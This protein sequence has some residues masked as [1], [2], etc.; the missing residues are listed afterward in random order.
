MI[1]KQDLVSLTLPQV[2]T[3]VLNVQNSFE[4][5]EN[6]DKSR[7]IQYIHDNTIKIKI[8]KKIGFDIIKSS[9]FVIEYVYNE[10]ISRH[11][12][13]E[14][15]EFNDFESFFEYVE[16]KIYDFSC[17]Y[18]YIFSEEEISKYDIDISKINFDS[19][20][21][22]DITKKTFESVVSDSKLQNQ[23]AIEN[24]IKI[25]KWIS[26]INNI[27]SYDSFIKKYRYFETKFT[28]Y[29]ATKI[30]FSLLIQKFG[31]LI[32]DYIVEFRRHN[33]AYKGLDI[34]DILFYYGLESAEQVLVGFDDGCAKSTI[35]RHK[36]IIKDK[37]A[38]FQNDDLIIQKKG[39][40][41]EV[42]QLYEVNYSYFSNKEKIPF[43]IVEKYLLTF[44]DFLK[45]LDFDLSGVNL[46][47]APISSNDVLKYKTDET[48]KLPRPDNYALYRVEKFYEDHQF[49]VVQYW[50]DKNEN[51]IISNQ[52][53]FQFFC[54]FAHYLNNDL[55]NA[56]LIMCDG[57]EKISS[58]KKI[59]FLGVKVRSE[60]AK[61]FNIKLDTLPKDKYELNEFE[62]TKKNELVTIN[63]LE[64][65]RATDEDYSCRV[66]Y[67]T[68]IH[69]IHRFAAWKCETFSDLEY[70]IKV[71]T[72]TI[73]RDLS[74]IKLIGGDIASDFKLYKTFIT[75]L[76]NQNENG[77]IFITL[78]NH[79]LWPF[80]DCFLDFIVNQYKEVINENKM[81]LVHNNLFYFD[82]E[83][84][85]ISTQ[86]LAEVSVEELRK[87]MRDA[88]LIIFGGI[89][90]AGKNEEFNANF[91]IYR[92]TISRK[93]EVEQSNLF[94][95]LYSK[96]VDALYDKNVIIFTHMPINDWTTNKYNK[97][98]VYVSGHNH[99]NY[100]HD[101]GVERVYS[102]NQIGYKQKNLY[103]KNFSINIG[104]D[105]FS[106]YKDGI[107]EISKE[108][109]ILFYKGIGERLSFN[110]QYYKLYMLKREETYMFLMR[111]LSGS[112]LILNGGAIKNG[113]NHSIEYFYDNL[114]T[115]SK[116]IKM[117]LSSFD[118]FQK[119]VSKEIKSI[120]GDGRIHGSIVDI[121]F[122]NHLYLNPLD[123]TITPYYAL[124]IVNKYIY[125]NIPSLLK[126]ECP[127]LY[128]NYEKILLNKNQ[129]K[130]LVISNNNNF[131]IIKSTTRVGSTEMYKV[132]RI[133]KGLQF[134]TKYNIVRLWNDAI[135]GDSSEENGRLIVSGIIN[136]EEM[137][138]KHINKEE[139]IN[140]PIISSFYPEEIV[141]K[142]L[143]E[144]KNKIAEFT[145]TIEVLEYNGYRGKSKYKCK[146]CGHIWEQRHDH[147]KGRG[148]L[149]YVCQKCKK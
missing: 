42:N 89:G 142:K 1:N 114:V 139:K 148:I 67:V 102:D 88:A 25:R 35:S 95:S 31:E 36:K 75:C 82:G 72:S 24:G 110:R 84:K 97:G 53:S 145:Q 113:G 62:K 74:T 55:S 6:I 94:E 23:E 116:S 93:Q 3:K 19:F 57:L 91:G 32:K 34:E 73:G 4:E 65:Q 117:F 101:D 98:F 54:D 71:I 33:E 125:M 80:E 115:Y 81:F 7:V 121:D 90:F 138:L 68:D 13:I 29:D 141:R 77:K 127:K 86:E 56:N 118:E 20:I 61:K 131:E 50:L 100:F 106:D 16:G 92:K 17:Y 45:E 46:E 126:F 87:K 26:R 105:W 12:D 8:F 30:F 83:W 43:M 5:L 48:T 143:D 119:K 28:F 78:G 18:G 147:F 69:M 21:D 63:E 103:M 40:F 120:G 135:I 129:G 96:I 51:L 134:T 99:K 112:L 136:P 27:D 47:N 64:T 9:F 39:H 44:H 146:L 22:Y 104:Y 76:R 85:E 11:Y 58:I 38:S 107:Y 60:V 137:E 2:I 140:E 108:D 132:S 130:D 111:A 79:E 41:S 59:N 14:R 66:S 49:Y 144:Y 133:L 123:G 122:Y 109:Y 128:A 124:S 10:D 37:I 70:V 149:H 15:N 52:E